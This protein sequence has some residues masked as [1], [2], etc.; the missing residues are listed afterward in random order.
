MIC[1]NKLD[2]EKVRIKTAYHNYFVVFY[3]Y[4]ECWLTQSFTPCYSNR[5]RSPFLLILWKGWN[6]LGSLIWVAKMCATSKLMTGASPNNN[7]F[8]KGVNLP[9]KNSGSS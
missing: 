1:I 3:Q 9:Q 8:T 6:F 7:D 4:M 5:F 2:K